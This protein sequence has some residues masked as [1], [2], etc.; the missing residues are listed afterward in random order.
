MD[1]KKKILIAIGGAAALYG[2][3][4][5]VFLLVVK[6]AEGHGPVK[7]A[8][9]D[10]QDRE[11]A[12]S[13]SSTPPT[14]PLKWGHGAAAKKY[15]RGVQIICNKWVGAGLAKDGIW[16]KATEAAVQS[17]AK[18]A[19]VRKSGSD[20]YFGALETPFPHCISPVTSPLNEQSKVQIYVSRYNE[21]VRWHNAN[22]KNYKG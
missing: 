8:S 12:A 20:N 10:E 21:M 16:G 7:P 22:Y 5:L 13:Y 1:K 15:V 18:V 6:I 19:R 4:L 14:F 3:G 11:G 9:E 2:L 17:L